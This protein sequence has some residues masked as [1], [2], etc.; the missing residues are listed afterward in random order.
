MAPP[1]RSSFPKCGFETQAG[2]NGPNNCEV[3]SDRS[4]RSG[5]Q[6]LCAPPNLHTEVRLG[7]CLRTRAGRLRTGEY[8][9]DACGF[10]YQRLR[11]GGGEFLLSGL[12][13]REVDEVLQV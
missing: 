10:V 4:I 2:P 7:R 1:T 12:R 11:L 6:H 5:R 13:H 9:A 3:V 8:G